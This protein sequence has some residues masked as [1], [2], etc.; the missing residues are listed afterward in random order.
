[1]DD[2]DG[3]GRHGGVVAAPLYQGRQGLGGRDGATAHRAP[4]NLPPLELHHHAP[5][6]RALEL[7][8]YS[9][10]EDPTPPNL[11]VI[12]QWPL[13]AV[14]GDGE[15]RAV[16]RDYSPLLTASLSMHQHLRANLWLLIL[17]VV[18]GCVLYPGILWG[19]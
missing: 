19:I 17:S 18:I 6:Q 2:A 9:G 5:R 1:D 13:R 7:T 11:E 10:P 14:I 12:N 4:S 15:W 16:L 3:A 8:P